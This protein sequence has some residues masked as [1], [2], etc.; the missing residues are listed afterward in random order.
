VDEGDQIDMWLAPVADN[1]ALARVHHVEVIE[2]T[3]GEDNYEILVSV[4]RSYI[5]KNWKGGN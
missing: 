2:Y 4:D 5:V 3:L 1:P